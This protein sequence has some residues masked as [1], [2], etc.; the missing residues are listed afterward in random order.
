M[1]LKLT[2]FCDMPV[3]FDAYVINFVRADGKT[4]AI[5]VYEDGSISTSDINDIRVKM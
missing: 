5:I 2:H 3:S 1:K 4:L